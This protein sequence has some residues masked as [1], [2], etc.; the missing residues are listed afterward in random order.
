MACIENLSLFRGATAVIILTT[1]A[2]PFDIAVAIALLFLSMDLV[3]AKQAPA[4]ANS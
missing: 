1:I 3:E 2:R 4:Q